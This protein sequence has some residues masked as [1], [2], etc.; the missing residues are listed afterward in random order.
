MPD[1]APCRGAFSTRKRSTKASSSG[2]RRW[3]N[4]LWWTSARPLGSVLWQSRARR[5]V[6]STIH[7]C[8]RDFYTE[9]EHPLLGKYK[10]QSIPFKLSKTPAEISRPAPLIGQHTREV[11]TELLGLSLQ[12]LREGYTDG[13]FWPARMPLYPYIEE[14]LT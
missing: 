13:T 9:L 5:T 1:S 6:W 10:I 2:P 12:D 4:T 3:R 8:A 14:T 11:L 7:S